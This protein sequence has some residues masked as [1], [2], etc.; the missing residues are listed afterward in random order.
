[1]FRP[2]VCSLFGLAWL[3]GTPA[4]ADVQTE[5][6]DLYFGEAMYQAYQENYFDAIVRLDTELGQHYNLDEPELG[7]L[8][9]HLNQAEFF[10]GDFELA[11]RM[12]RR[13]GRAIEA[14]MEGKVSQPV[15]NEAAYR[16]ARI[17]FKKNQPVNALHVLQRIEGEIPEAVRA[18]ELFL[19]GQVLIATG[20]F[21]EAI[22][23]LQRVQGEPGLEG[24]AGFNLGVALIQ[25]DRMEEG[26][27]QLDR[28][29]QISSND[30]AVQG[31]R[32]KAN[33]VLGYRLLDTGEPAHAK[34]YLE[35]V[36]LDG[37]L[38]N[39]ALLGA[40]WA[41][42]LQE[43]FERALVPWSILA[44]R[45]PTNEYVQEAMLSVPY[46]Y[47]KLGVYGKSAINY[48]QALDRFAA[49]L[50]SL[51]NSIKSIREGKFLQALVDERADQDEAWLVHLRNLP[52]APE[53][54]YILQLMT[55]HDFQESLKNY[56]E[57]G[58]LHERMEKW[59]G[60]ID[61]YTQLVGIRRDYYE[62]ILPAI[63]QQFRKL[64]SR[65]KLRTEQRDRLDERIQRLLVA[66]NPDFLATVNERRY[67]KKL[68]QL[69]TVI[70]RSGKSS[71][72]SWQRV[73]RLKGVILW[74]IYTEYDERLTKAYKNLR[75][76][77]SH[78]E[79]LDNRYQSFVRTFHGARQSYEGYD[80][81]LRRL[82]SR[83]GQTL[84]RL[85][86]VRAR[87]GRL[88]ELMAINELDR[89]RKRLE[90]YQI[91]ARFAL[92]ENYDK[93]TKAGQ[94]QNL[95]KPQVPDK[96]SP[97]NQPQSEGEQ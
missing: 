52:D 55:S 27:A 80:I 17:L 97:E 65:M 26:F 8:H 67:L 21:T 4:Q 20:R 12:H 28:V 43:N 92:A 81:P 96:T 89:R 83:I 62:P 40:G 58:K 44:K 91:K 74:P 73:Q 50:T 22:E 47:G 66:R 34:T 70:K 46:A 77:D 3:V 57:L 19:R 6:R 16:L 82:Q 85:E 78:I 25:A 51:D 15:R 1:M 9:Y 88:L 93:A 23:V 86:R 10:V 61:A 14:V 2:L 24:F 36:R 48:G 84:D 42:A 95:P 37:P 79:R 87:Q 18:K 11:Y 72:P 59:L 63:E 69:E 13:A 54:H 29:G 30:P 49:E 31:I 32:D 60:S 68:Q 76:L 94:E 64:D 35:R 5:L 90:E 53:T 45:N 33:L 75:Q 7:S 39:R 41:D 38:S 71:G 56:R